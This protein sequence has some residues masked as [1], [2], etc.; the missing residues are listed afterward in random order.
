MQNSVLEE[1][2]VLQLQCKA[3]QPGGLKVE[4]LSNAPLHVVQAVSRRLIAFSEKLP[5]KGG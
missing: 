4:D 5:A 3:F 1:I 2:A